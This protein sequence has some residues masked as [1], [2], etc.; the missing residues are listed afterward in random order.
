MDVFNEPTEEGYLRTNTI[1]G[2]FGNS[3]T[4]ND[5]CDFVVVV[6]DWSV[7][8]FAYEYGTSKVQGSFG[9]ETFEVKVRDASGDWSFTAH[10]PQGADRIYLARVG[11]DH[12]Q[13]LLDSLAAGGRISFK[14]TENDSFGTPSTYLFTIE[15]AS[16]LNVAYEQLFGVKL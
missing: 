9:D 12:Y 4:T 5:K 15:D 11:E 8:L 14:L 13:R 1:R 7:T 3:V 10:M 16:G 2:S 6:D